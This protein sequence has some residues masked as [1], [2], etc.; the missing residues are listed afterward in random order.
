MIFLC[1]ALYFTHFCQTKWDQ[2]SPNEFH[3]NE[4][5]EFSIVASSWWDENMVYET[6]E[7][8]GHGGKQMNKVEGEYFKSWC[9]IERHGV[10]MSHQGHVVIQAIHW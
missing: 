10:I 2:S 7:A 6:S 1:Y 3:P 8:G 5:E 9:W 4:A